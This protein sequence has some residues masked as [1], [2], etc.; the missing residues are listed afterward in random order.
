MNG[1]EDELRRDRAASIEARRELGPA[2]EDELVQSF[3]DRIDTTIRA[4]VDER[5]GED[6]GGD[7][8]NTFPFVMGLVSLGTGIPITAIASSSGGTEGIVVAWLGIVGVN[9]AFALGRVRRR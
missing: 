1:D 5:V 7:D 9:A 4:R 3:V 6:G 2:Y 8:D